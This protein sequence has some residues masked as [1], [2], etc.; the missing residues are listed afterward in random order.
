MSPKSNTWT[1]IKARIAAGDFPAVFITRAGK[2]ALDGSAA[3]LPAAIAALYPAEIRAAAEAKA[4]ERRQQD[5]ADRD[6]RFALAE[7]QEAERQAVIDQFGDTRVWRLAGFY[8]QETSS[9]RFTWHEISQWVDWDAYNLRHDRPSVA[10]VCERG[11]GDD[12]WLD[13]SAHFDNPS[14]GRR[15]TPSFAE[16]VKRLGDYLVMRRVNN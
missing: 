2:L 8:V 11:A 5:Q 9:E 14:G 7:E 3:E 6:R 4:A 12:Y 10:A 13:L 15:R 16:L 1:N